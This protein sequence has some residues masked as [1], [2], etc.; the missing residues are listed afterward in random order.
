MACQPWLVFVSQEHIEPTFFC[1]LCLLHSIT[2]DKRSYLSRS[3]LAKPHMMGEN[4]QSLV[5]VP[6][7]GERRKRRR[8]SYTKPLQTRDFIFTLHLD[9]SSV[10]YYQAFFFNSSDEGQGFLHTLLGLRRC[11][12]GFSLESALY[13]GHCWPT[14]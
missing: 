5:G 4:F 13:K 3:R 11:N 7:C 14:L 6:A 8:I 12:H 1:H 10:Y 2:F 9:S